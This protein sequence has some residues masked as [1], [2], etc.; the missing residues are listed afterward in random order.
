MLTAT[1]RR[2]SKSMRGNVGVYAVM[3]AIKFGWYSVSGKNLQ[4]SETKVLHLSLWSTRMLDFVWRVGL[5][6]MLLWATRISM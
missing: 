4:Q 5:N 3:D 2:I 6:S 1:H